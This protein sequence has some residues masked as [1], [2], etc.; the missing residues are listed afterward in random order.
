MGHSSSG[1]FGVLSLGQFRGLGIRG[2]QSR[3]DLAG[4]I[5]RRICPRDRPCIGAEQEQ[6][7]L[8]VGNLLQQWR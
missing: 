1:R 7:A 4:Q 5:Q 2:I 6:D 8:R 3:N